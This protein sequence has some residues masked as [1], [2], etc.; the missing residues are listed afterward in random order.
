MLTV[1]GYAIACT[2]SAASSG[3]RDRELGPATISI[4]IRILC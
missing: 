3:A 1:G 2:A 4:T